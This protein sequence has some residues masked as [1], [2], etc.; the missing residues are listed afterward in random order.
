VQ[1][2]SETARNPEGV[3]AICAMFFTSVLLRP[4]VLKLFNGV[5][6]LMAY[7]AERGSSAS[8]V[9]AGHLPFVGVPLGFPVR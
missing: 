6:Q 8:S 1:P 3:L 4:N 9:S 2:R 7:A 5:S